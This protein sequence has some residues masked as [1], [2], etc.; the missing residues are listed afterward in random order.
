M[1]RNSSLLP[2]WSIK[3][4]IDSG[5]PIFLIPK[6]QFNRITP[7]KPIQTENRDVNDNRIRF[8]GKNRNSINKREAKQPLSPGNNKENQLFIRFELDGEIGNNA[9]YR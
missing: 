6:S 8:E 5:S 4:I 2:H 3:F 9:G 7:L 1:V